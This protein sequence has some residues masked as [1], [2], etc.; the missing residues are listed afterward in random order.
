MKK[1]FATIRRRWKGKSKTD[2]KLKERD[3]TDCI[4]LAQDGNEKI[5]VKAGNFQ[6]NQLVRQRK[7]QLHMYCVASSYMFRSAGPHSGYLK[8]N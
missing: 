5:P 6:L 7:T 2:P 1:P 4:L 3:A 8:K